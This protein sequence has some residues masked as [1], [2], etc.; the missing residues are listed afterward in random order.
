MVSACCHLHINTLTSTYISVRSDV[1]AS[2]VNNFFLN[3]IKDHLKNV[4]FSI[5]SGDIYTLLIKQ[6]S[7]R[8]ITTHC[9]FL[10]FSHFSS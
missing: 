5:S 6:L 2:R 9:T 1:A 8:T 4:E 3:A 10:S 7:I